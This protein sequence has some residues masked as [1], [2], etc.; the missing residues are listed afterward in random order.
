MTLCA[1]GLGP[2]FE[3]KLLFLELHEARAGVT[4]THSMHDLAACV[5]KG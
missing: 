3:E 5:E 2:E 1:F 4:K